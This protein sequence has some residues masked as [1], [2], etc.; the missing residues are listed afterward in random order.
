MVILLAPKFR[1]L[2]GL[3]EFIIPLHC[4]GQFATL[5]R[6]IKRPIYIEEDTCWLTSIVQKG[7]AANAAESSYGPTPHAPVIWWRVHFY[8]THEWMNGSASYSLPVP[9]QSVCA[10]PTQLQSPNQTSMTK[11]LAQGSCRIG[12]YG[13]VGHPRLPWSK[14]IALPPLLGRNS[15]PAASPV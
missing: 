7:G 3:K 9:Y 4:R 8:A 6:T 11:R 2:F 10:L 14:H 13:L 1:C 12:S 15:T 5:P